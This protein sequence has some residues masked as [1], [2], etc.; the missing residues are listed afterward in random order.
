MNKMLI[1]AGV[2]NATAALMHIGC[3][4]FDAP[5]YRFFGA[6]EQMAV[7]AERGSL[8]P[9][10]ITS[11]IVVVLSI[12]S[13]Y[14]FSAADVI[15]R[16]PLMRLVLIVI[17]TIY[18]LRGVAGLFFIGNTMGRSAAFWLWSSAICLCVG[19]IHLIGLK[20]QWAQL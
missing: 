5:W 16:L 18:L 17:S 8:Q 15:T 3:I 6:G 10:I 12:W 9:T 4:Y 1:F 19:L 7:M 2:F 11:G 13:V 20:Q 14:A